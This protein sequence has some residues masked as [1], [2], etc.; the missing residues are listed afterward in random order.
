MFL[1][2]LV[3]SQVLLG[4]FSDPFQF[5]LFLLQEIGQMTFVKL[6][7]CAYQMKK[8]MCLED[9]GMKNLLSIMIFIELT[10]F[11]ILVLMYSI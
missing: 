9:S 3:I 4:N 1:G 11:D 8:K 7:V 2:L 5:T 10:N 6:H